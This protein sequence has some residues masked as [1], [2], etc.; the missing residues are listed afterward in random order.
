MTDSL[1]LT[2]LQEHRFWLEILQDHA[3]FLQERLNPREEVWREEALRHRKALA[4]LGDRLETL[5]GLP[6]ASSRQW[7][8]YAKEAHMTAASYYHLEGRV[9][10]LLLAND[11]RMNADPAHLNCTLM[12]NEEYLRLLEYYVQGAE[13]PRLPLWNLMELWLDD[14]LNHARQLCGYMQPTDRD[15]SVKAGALADEFR[16]HLLHNKTILGFLRFTPP[17]F[18]EQLRFARDAAASV[19][20]MFRLL[21]E[22]AVALRVRA[23]SGSIAVRMIEHQLPETSYFMRK[24]SWFIP[25]QPGLVTDRLSKAPAAS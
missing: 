17:G 3:S 7:I 13:A 15:L 24:L 23:E 14:Q 25:D 11:I 6:S 2:V 22:A 1:S 8:D 5:G 12:E 21:E 19:V 4:R 10:A 18:P 9:Q 16:S 20:R